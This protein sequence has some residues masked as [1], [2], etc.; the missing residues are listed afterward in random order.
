MSIAVSTVVEPSRIL[1]LIVMTMA[2]LSLGISAYFVADISG[3]T[4]IFARI[5]IPVFSLSAAVATWRWIKSYRIPYRIDLSGTG[6]VRFFPSDILSKNVVAPLNDGPDDTLF[7]LLPTSTTW[8]SM[9]VLN[10]R[11]ATGLSATAIILPDCVTPE[12]FRKLSVACRWISGRGGH[13]DE[14][15]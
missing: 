6:E 9:L 2:L 4:P 5:A 10:L 15:T 7:C 3:S 12:C 14:E 13:L 8:S 11:S 1:L